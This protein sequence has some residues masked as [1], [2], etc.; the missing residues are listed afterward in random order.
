M[1]KETIS[2]VR[3]ILRSDYVQID[4]INAMLA[5]AIIV[6][7]FIAFISGDVSLFGTVFILGAALAL[8]NFI[9]SVMRKSTMGIIVF[10]GIIPVMIGVAFFIFNY[11]G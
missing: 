11:I 9:K 5:V 3:H 2:Y 10:L 8:F 1:N 7:S 4:F 6:V